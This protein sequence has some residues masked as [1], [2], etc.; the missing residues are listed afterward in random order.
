MCGLFRM[1][2]TVDVRSI[3]CCQI[4]CECIQRPAISDN[5]VQ[6][7]KQHMLVSRQR[8]QFGSQSRLHCKIKAVT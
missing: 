6:R 7:H 3:G 4:T 8:E 5:M 1:C 2:I